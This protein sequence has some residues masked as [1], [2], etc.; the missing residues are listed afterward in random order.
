MEEEICPECPHSEEVN[1]YLLYLLGFLELQEAGCPIERH[2]LTNPQWKDLLKVRIE[3]DRIVAEKAKAK[4][5]DEE[6]SDR[7][8]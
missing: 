5:E 4:R 7:G 6:Q 1:P 2:E 8:E 3:R